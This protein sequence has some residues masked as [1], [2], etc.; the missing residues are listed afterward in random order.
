MKPCLICETER[1]PGQ[2]LCAGCISSLEHHRRTRQG[3]DPET[4]LIAWAARRAR[5]VERRKTEEHHAFLVGLLREAR[6]Q[7]PASGFTRLIDETT[8]G[9]A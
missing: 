7:L 2:T 6:R 4:E 5:T 8:G 1:V 3:L 9:D